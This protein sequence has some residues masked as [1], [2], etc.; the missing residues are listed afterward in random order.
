VGNRPASVKIFIPND[1]SSRVL[2]YTI[3][4]LFIPCVDR[5]IQENMTPHIRAPLKTYWAT[6]QSA[7]PLLVTVFRGAHNKLTL[8]KRIGQTG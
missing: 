3:E 1:P 2:V 8:G 6:S 4:T 7:S 5:V